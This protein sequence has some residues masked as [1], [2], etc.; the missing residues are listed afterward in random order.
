MEKAVGESGR[1][2]LNAN[3]RATERLVRA[4]SIVGDNSRLPTADLF[5]ERTCVLSF[6]NSHAVNLAC[7][8]PEF[9]ELLLGANLLLRD[10]VGMSLLYRWI[11]LDPGLNM[12]G[13]DYIPKVLAAARGAS[14]ALYGSSREVADAAGERLRS[15]GVNV[16]SSKDGFLPIAE[17]ANCVRVDRPRV[18]VLGMGMPKQEAVA[19]LLRTAVSEPILI[20][21]GGAILD[22]LADRFQRAPPWLRRLGLEWLFRLVLEPRRL[23]RRYI[24]GNIVFLARA[25]ALAIRMRIARNREP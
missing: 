20:I 24:L 15:M 17:Y 10:G 3:T 25:A 6:V 11:G 2:P 19:Q 23:W 8:N 4:I 18:V 1:T 9:L 16:I 12:N 21:N 5:L 14:V 7:A 13:T 22:F